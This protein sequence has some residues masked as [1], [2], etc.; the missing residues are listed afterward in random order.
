MRLLVVSWLKTDTV[1]YLRERAMVILALHPK[2]MN[3]RRQKVSLLY[4]PPF[5][6]AC[7]STK[8]I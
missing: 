5:R 2:K 8:K 4:K 7:I 3:F 6:S 1:T